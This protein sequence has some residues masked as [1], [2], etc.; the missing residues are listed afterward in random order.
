MPHQ[1]AYPALK[2]VFSAFSVS[3][4]SSNR[5]RLSRFRGGPLGHLDVLLRRGGNVKVGVV[6]GPGSAP[7]AAVVQVDDVIEER[8][9]VYGS[10]AIAVPAAEEVLFRQILDARLAEEL[11]AAVRRHGHAERTPARRL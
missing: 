1:A 9:E 6:H 2:T 8:A 10:P 3:Q 7:A 4:S 11:H 5:L